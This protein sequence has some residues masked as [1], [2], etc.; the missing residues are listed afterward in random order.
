[1]ITDFIGN[2]SRLIVTYLGIIYPLF[3]FMMTEKK[4]KIIFN[5]KKGN[6]RFGHLGNLINKPDFRD[7]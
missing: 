6:N 4:K 2:V 1:M 5:K 7:L 3:I